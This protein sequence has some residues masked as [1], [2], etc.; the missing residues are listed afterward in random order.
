[1]NTIYSLP[2]LV[3]MV[4]TSHF[5]YDFFE[6]TGSSRAVFWII[7][8]VIWGVLEL[9][10]LGLIGGTAPGGTARYLRQSSKR[11]RRGLRLLGGDAGPLRVRLAELRRTARGR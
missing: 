9:N 4:G 3:F 10:A 2:M 5:P 8:I 7:W 1:M 6:T 11:H